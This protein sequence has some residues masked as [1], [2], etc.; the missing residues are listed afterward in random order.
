LCKDFCFSC[1]VYNKKSQSKMLAPYTY[2]TRPSPPHVC[3]FP[4]HPTSVS[5][6]QSPCCARS[7]RRSQIKNEIPT[8]GKSPVARPNPLA[9][10]LRSRHATVLMLGGYAVK[11]LPLHQRSPQPQVVCQCVGRLHGVACHARAALTS[12][13]RHRGK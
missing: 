8:Q 3:G 11:T 10:I 6:P 7:S 2:S 4:A 12:A 13:P 1:S 9:M 5:S